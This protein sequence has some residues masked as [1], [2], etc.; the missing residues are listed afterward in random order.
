MYINGQL[1]TKFGN[2]GYAIT[3]GGHVS[4]MTGDH[5]QPERQLVYRG[6]PY[7]FHLHLFLE[8]GEWKTKNYS[9]CYISRR[10]G[11]DPT[12]VAKKTIQEAVTEAWAAY[13]ALHP[14]L[15]EKAEGLRLQSDLKSHDE[16]L[17]KLEGERGE[18]LSERTKLRNKLND[19]LDRN[20]WNLPLEED[21]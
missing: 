5:G 18:L 15:L 3:N 17:A 1:G 11:P 19:L 2:I 10:N 9:D 20:K 16:K 12:S 14:E 4:L 6:N 13:I 7:Y 8:G 21:E